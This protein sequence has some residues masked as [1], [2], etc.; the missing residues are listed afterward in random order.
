LMVRRGGRSGHCGANGDGRV[1]S[2]VLVGRRGDDG[3]GAGGQKLQHYL[4]SLLGG[5]DFAGHGEWAM[6]ARYAG[7]AVCRD[8]SST[9]VVPSVA[10]LTEVLEFF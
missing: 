8:G 1:S 5:V 9:S 2:R 7:R 6:P 10:S 3:F 4:R